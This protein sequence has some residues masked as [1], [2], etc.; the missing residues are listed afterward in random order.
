MRTRMDVWR[1]PMTVNCGLDLHRHQI[2]FDWVDSETG[3]CARGRIAPADRSEFRGWL[4]GFADR[5]LEVVV[6]GCTGWRFVAEE[7][8][9]VGTKVHVADPGEAASI[10]R[11]H[12]KRAKTDRVDARH[13]RGLL[14]DH[15]VPESWVPP[16][17][18]LEA[19]ALV[20]LYSD[21]V[22]ERSRW[23][24]RIHATLFH[25]GALPQRKLL[26]G[27]RDLLHASPALSPAGREA[28]EAALVVIDALDGQVA[29]VRAQ[30][31]AFAAR[32]PGCVELQR[33]YGVGRLY[34]V[35]IWAEL[36]DT[37]RF[38]SSDDA[39]RHTGLDITVHS[40]DG[41]RTA[42]RLT[43]QGPPLLRW[44]LYEAARHASRSGSPDHEYYQRAAARVGA[45]RAT[46]SVARK[47]TRRCH[48]RLRALGDQAFAELPDVQAA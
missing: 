25:H 28:I 19:R 11:S 16:P 12:K 44:A 45:Q 37:A 36:G 9:R 31:V 18:A 8:R 42:G 32:Q 15:T 23:L 39:V 38:S 6:E 26:L 1:F 17:Q 41:K 46:L 20:R 14:E 34:A 35:I 13:L 10:G 33:E 30:L 2:T 24:Q 29:R 5:D 7:C 3:E 27:D 48:H 43:R 47:L 22:Q 4:A 40:S 21:L